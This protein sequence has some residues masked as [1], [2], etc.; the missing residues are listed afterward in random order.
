VDRFRARKE[1]RR[2]D[3]N[4]KVREGREGALY[5]TGK[6]KGGGKGGVLVPYSY[7]PTLKGKKGEDPTTTNGRKGTGQ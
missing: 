2:S 6:K 3:D 5:G 1:G 7:A 4:T